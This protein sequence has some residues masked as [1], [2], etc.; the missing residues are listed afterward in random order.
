[1]VLKNKEG[2]PELKGTIRISH[3]IPVPSSELELYDLENET[4]ENYKNL[5]KN[6]LEYI[7][8]NENKIKKNA[9]VMYKQKKD[10]ENIGYVKSALEFQKIE[11]LCTAFIKENEKN[12]EELA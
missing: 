3:M 10:N 6:E 2:K 11:V 9:E 4:D 12:N 7:R 1:M 5:V 8:R